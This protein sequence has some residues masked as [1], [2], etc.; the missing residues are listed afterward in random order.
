MK[1]QLLTNPYTES[2][3]TIDHILKNR[4]IEDVNRY[5]HTTDN[6]INSFF[7]LGVENLRDAAIALVSAIR[8][9]TKTIVVVDCDC[10]GYTSAAFLLNYLHTLFPYWI[11]NYVDYYLH[12]SKQHGLNDCIDYILDKEYGLVI[13]PDSSSNDGEYHKRLK[14]IGADVIVLDHHIVDEKVALLIL[15]IINYVHILIKIYLVLVLSISFVD[16]LIVFMELIMLK[17]F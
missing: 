4:G 10:D 14:D 3:E 17:V 8:R 11:E 2:G 15:L 12:D 5:L 1:Y 7:L 6:D 16:I 9:D 13:T